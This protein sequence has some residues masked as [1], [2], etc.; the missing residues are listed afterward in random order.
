[1][2]EMSR[3]LLNNFGKLFQ[4]RGFYLAVA[5]HGNAMGRQAP[6]GGRG[7]MRLL[8]LFTQAPDG[9]TNAEI[10]Q[11]LDIRPSSVSAMISRLEDKGLVQRVPSTTDKRTM[12]IE[13]TAQGQEMLAHQSERTD[14][15]ADTL[16][17]SL[18]AEQ[19]AQLNE[20]IVKLNQNVTDFEPQHFM[21]HHCQGGG[22]GHHGEHCCHGEG[23]GHGQDGE[24]QCCHGEGGHHH[25]PQHHGG[26]GRG[27]WM[28]Q[29]WR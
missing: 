4:N 8:Q 20:L 23:G 1:M 5:H 28:D 13:L 12:I 21:Q 25:G 24:H 10:S 15:L 17:D 2:S 9:L 29:D 7:P 22:R 6:R 19:Q 16:F 14:D 3:E 27:P 26:R 18:T 11:I